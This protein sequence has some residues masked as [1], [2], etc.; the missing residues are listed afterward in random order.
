MRLLTETGDGSVLNKDIV[1]A[2]SKTKFIEVEIEVEQYE[3]HTTSDEDDEEEKSR[4][5]IS[6]ARAKSQKQTMNH[7]ELFQKKMTRRF[8]KSA[9]GAGKMDEGED[10]EI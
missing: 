7:L 5:D 6:P 10:E 3:S 8:A 4:E 2:E 9:K 1:E